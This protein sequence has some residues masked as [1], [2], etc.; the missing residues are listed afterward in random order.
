MQKSRFTDKQIIRALREVED[1]RPVGDICRAHGVARRA[2]LLATERKRSYS[3][4]EGALPIS[5]TAT[6]NGCSR[7]SDREPPALCPGFA[8]LPADELQVHAAHRY[9]GPRSN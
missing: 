8:A 9:L 5:K 6:R 3:R 2:L 7:S 4:T 1:E